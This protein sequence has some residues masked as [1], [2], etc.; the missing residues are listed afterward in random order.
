[1]IAQSEI[2]NSDA[3]LHIA[4]ELNE[5]YK[6]KI[7]ELPYRLNIIT[8][9]HANE[10]ANSRIL[11]GILQYQINN[12]YPLLRKFIDIVQNKCD[13]CDCNISLDVR[14][15]VITNEESRIDLL[16]K[17]KPKY[18]IVVE[19]KIWGAVDQDAQIERYVDYVLN[20]GIPQ[21]RIYVVYLTADGSK[22]VGDNS[23]TDPVKKKLGMSTNKK[24]RF[25]CINFKYDILPWLQE[26]IQSDIAKSEP[27]LCSALTQYVDY[28]KGIFG[29]RNED[30]II[31][32]Q[33]EIVAME[34]L[35]INSID[36]LLKAWG[37][38]NKLQDTICNT[39]N[40]R[41]E[42]LCI[43]KI[44]NAL[45]KKGYTIKA[46]DFKYDRFDLEIE[47]PEWKKSWWCIEQGSS[48]LYW[49]I[50]EDREKKVAPEYKLMLSDVYKNIEESGYI[51]WDWMNI[52]YNENFWIELEKHSAK[53]V[54]IVVAEIERVRAATNNMNL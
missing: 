26:I 20:C 29:L 45:E 19:N 42:S 33:L 21:K 37:D 51:A 28:L 36:E 52:E 5:L 2:T 9:L 47:I 48:G 23:L 35:Q 30:E 16:I 7:K 8:E 22:K 6:Q 13:K 15:P 38:V 14:F 31:R 39:A 18:A 41:I 49:G 53:F 24:G 17:E 4:A 1:M 46:Y 12:D 44:R 54:N 50:W 43:S 32:K 10:N 34:K 11:R 25:V 40:K 27:L 3:L